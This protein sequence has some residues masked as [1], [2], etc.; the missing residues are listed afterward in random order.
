V[1]LGFLGLLLHERVCV[2]GEAARGCEQQPF[3]LAALGEQALDQLEA[4][5][6][7]GA[8]HYY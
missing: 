6:S 4:E 3:V 2:L 7:G 1:V 5:R 8:D